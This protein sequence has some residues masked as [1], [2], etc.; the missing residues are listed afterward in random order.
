MLKVG[1]EHIIVTQDSRWLEL[2][3]SNAEMV[4]G[5]HI[6]LFAQVLFTLNL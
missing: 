5:H 6:S 1:L 2:K 3:D 4:S